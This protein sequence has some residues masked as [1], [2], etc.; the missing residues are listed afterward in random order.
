MWK[1]CAHNKKRDLQKNYSGKGRGQS[2]LCPLLKYATAVYTAFHVELYRAW[3]RSTVV[4]KSRT[5]HL[6]SR[7]VLHVARW[8]GFLRASIRRVLTYR[9]TNTWWIMLGYVVLYTPT[10][11]RSTF[12]IIGRNTPE[13][14]GIINF[15][16]ISRYG[17][18]AD[19]CIYYQATETKYD[20]RFVDKSCSLKRTG[21]S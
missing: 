21:N 9:K 4:I 15:K 13:W 16:K 3:C 5:R 19:Q 8:R 14:V 18:C 6:L 10:S 7:R 17:L 1:H 2:S 12:Q 11:S 20:S